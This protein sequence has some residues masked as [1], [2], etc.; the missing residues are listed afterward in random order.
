[1][2]RVQWIVRD[3]Q[4]ELFIL[5]ISSNERS[6]LADIEIEVNRTASLNHEPLAS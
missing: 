6:K 3:D 5:G 1:M 2:D 4:H